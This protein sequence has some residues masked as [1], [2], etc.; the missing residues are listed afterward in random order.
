MLVA[1]WRLYLYI[2]IIRNARDEKKKNSKE[3]KTKDK[4]A[5]VLKGGGGKLCIPGRPSATTLQ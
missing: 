4:G 5:G 1:E 3:K 2:R